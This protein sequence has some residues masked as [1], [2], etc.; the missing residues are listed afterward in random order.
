M[1]KQNLAMMIVASLFFTL[2]TFHQANSE[3]AKP[4]ELTDII[5]MTEAQDISIES[6]SVYMKEDTVYAEDHQKAEAVVK[7]LITEKTGYQWSNETPKNGH[8]QKEVGVKN[9]SD[10]SV[11]E[12][13]VIATYES[14]GLYHITV[15]HQLDGKGWTDE[16]LNKITSSLKGETIY[17]TVKGSKKQTGKIELEELA[18]LL[19]A[20]LSAEIKEGL[21]EDG[22]VSLSAYNPNWAISVP[23]GQSEEMNVQVGLR[24]S[25]QETVDV[26]IGT[27]IITTEY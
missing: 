7:E 18:Q 19:V 12:R 27:P 21:I 16:T 1:R 6:W 13:I 10:Q 24:V 14:N 20:G 9:Q 26:T 4:N 3:S 25:E 8:Y 22:F 2:Y 23:I 5:N 15:T 17:Y 11:R